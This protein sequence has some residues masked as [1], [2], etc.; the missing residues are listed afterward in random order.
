[1]G[2]VPGN[3]AGS[4]HSEEFRP[5]LLDDYGFLK[6]DQ[7]IVTYFEEVRQRAVEI[8]DESLDHYDGKNNHERGQRG[9]RPRQ[10][11]TQTKAADREEG[12]HNKRSQNRNGKAMMDG[13]RQPFFVQAN[14]I[15]ERLDK[16]RDGLRVRM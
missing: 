9:A 3:K 6:L 15:I 4:R 5:D 7:G 1:M 12:D 14:N 2:M 10:A 11:R 13:G 16:K 8:D